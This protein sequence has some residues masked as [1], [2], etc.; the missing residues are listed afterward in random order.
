MYSEAEHSRSGFQVARQSRLYESAPAY[1][2]DQPRFVN[3]ALAV[4]TTLP[5]IELLATLKRIEVCWS[6]D[7]E[8]PCCWLLEQQQRQSRYAHQ[9]DVVHS[10]VS[11]AASL[12][13]SVGRS[14][15]SHI[16][17]ASLPDV[18]VIWMAA[19]VQRIPALS[20]APHGG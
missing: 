7:R 11:K 2:T 9:S 8:H 5:P 18:I 3:A 1:V 13:E 10:R 15:C 16:F 6:R 12:A 17:G 19:Y 20:S 14:P 4:E